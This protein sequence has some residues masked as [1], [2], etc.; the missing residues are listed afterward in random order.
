MYNRR[1]DE[2]LMSSPSPSPFSSQSPSCLSTLLSS[3]H[4]LRPQINLQR[5]LIHLQTLSNVT[6]AKENEIQHPDFCPCL[7]YQ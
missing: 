7:E 1:F 2:H 6:K 3:I 4:T 5:P